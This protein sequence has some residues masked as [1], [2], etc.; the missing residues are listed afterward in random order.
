MLT[1]TSSNRL[2]WY[3]RARTDFSNQPS[4]LF[5]TSGDYI[6]FDNVRNIYTDPSWKVKVSKNIDASLPYKRVELLRWKSPRAL[7]INCF[8]PGGVYTTDP[9]QWAR[10]TGNLQSYLNPS[11]FFNPDYEDSALADLALK[12]LKNKLASKHTEQFNALVPLAE[13]REFRGLVSSSASLTARTVRE[14]LTLK[15]GVRNAFRKAQRIWL[16]YSFGISP[17][18]AETEGVIR[19]I[20]AY[21]LREDHSVRLTGTASREWL[22]SSIRKQSEPYVIPYY[23]TVNARSVL[24]HKLS[25]RYTAGI[26]VNLRSA[27]NYTM[28]DHLGIQGPGSLVPVLWELQAFSWM[29]D[30]FSTIGDYLEDV[31]QSDSTS[32]KY[33]TLN[34]RYE[35]LGDLFLD[36]GPDAPGSSCSYT[37]RPGSLHCLTFTRS[38]FSSLPT[39]QLRFK[40][41]QEIG[42]VK[43]GDGVTE[44][45]EVQGLN[46]LLNLISLL[47]V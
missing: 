10:T 13:L 25:Y 28:F 21:L 42:L 6:G 15:T 26:D 35:I 2:P 31:F 24:A 43:W 23:L 20:G 47:K 29:F 3:S 41:A 7:N 38:T 22:G 11:Y 5:N 32:T 37:P 27:N 12:R 44:V 1:V 34:K 39:R 19:S 40:T 45:Q 36:V 4:I 8:L 17:M 30:Y 33:V 46:K 14:L 9:K 16:T 18:M